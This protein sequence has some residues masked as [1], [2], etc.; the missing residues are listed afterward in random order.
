MQASK[1]LS[2][3]PGCF[4]AA[5]GPIRP[6]TLRSNCVSAG[7]Q[8]GSSRHAPPPAKLTG[9]QSS[10]QARRADR[11]RVRREEGWVP[12]VADLLRH[13]LDEPGE[14]GGGAEPGG[15]HEGLR[16]PMSRVCPSWVP[17]SAARAM[18]LARR[19]VPVTRSICHASSAPAPVGWHRGWRFPA[20]A[21]PR[22]ATRPSVPCA[23]RWPSRS[24]DANGRR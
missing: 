14:C 3:C 6:H 11:V 12:R 9:Q 8:R 16:P 20:A 21:A 13:R 1:Q 19:R 23:R 15:E 4:P 7:A 24:P 17:T 22:P 2:L 18:V 5:R 10:Q